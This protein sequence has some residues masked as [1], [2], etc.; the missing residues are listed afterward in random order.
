MHSYIIEAQGKRYCRTREHVQPIHFNLPPPVQQQQNPQTKQC[1]LGPSLPKPRIPRPS[2]S[3]PNL[4]RPSILP[5]LPVFLQSYHSY[6]CTFLAKTILAKQVLLATIVAR[7]SSTL[8]HHQ[9]ST[10]LV[11]NQRNL[12]HH[13]HLTQHLTLPAEPEKELEA[14]SPSPPDIQASTASYSLCP[15]LPITYN[16]TAL[17]C[18]CKG[19]QRLKY[20]ITC[21][22]PFPV[23]VSAVHQMT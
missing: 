13:Q 6:H 14:E 21:P 4:S 8:V 9:P 7:P 16:E 23:T 15:K 20:A 12:R 19:D 2:R 22:Y 17:S 3:I 18:L 1:I 5:S 10:M 11:C